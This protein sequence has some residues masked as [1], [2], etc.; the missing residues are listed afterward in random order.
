MATD[1]TS[2]QAGDNCEGGVP[3]DMIVVLGCDHGTHVAG[4]A[5]GSAYSD[6]QNNNYQ[7]IGMAPESGIVAVQVF[8]RFSRQD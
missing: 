5:A 1:T 6:E 4:I 7:T 8:T 2:E 3:G